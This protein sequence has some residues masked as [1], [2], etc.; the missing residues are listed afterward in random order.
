MA[1]NATLATPIRRCKNISPIQRIKKPQLICQNKAKARIRTPRA[2]EN[3]FGAGFRVRFRREQLIELAKMGAE[4]IKVQL[5]LHVAE[6][7]EERSNE[8]E[9]GEACQ[10]TNNECSPSCSTKCS[11]A[12]KEYQHGAV[13]EVISLPTLSPETQREYIIET[14]GTKFLFRAI[15]RGF[16]F[17]AV[18]SSP[19]SDPCQLD[20][21]AQSSILRL[22][23]KINDG[24]DEDEEDNDEYDNQPQTDNCSNNQNNRS[25]TTQKAILDEEETS[26]KGPLTRSR[27]R[28]TVTANPME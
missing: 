22:N 19:C 27:A 16:K 18:D 9:S 1:P 5:G 21:N 26:Y 10:L 20:K 23:C 7:P 28:R 3:T 4:K 14:N 8:N 25:S 13:R 6:H 15:A 24:D 12:M 17:A 11:S 2:L